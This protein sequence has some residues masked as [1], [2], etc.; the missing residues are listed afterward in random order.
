MIKYYE[1]CEMYYTDPYPIQRGRGLFNVDRHSLQR[2]RGLGGI[3]ASLLK[4]VIPFGKSFVKQAASSGK[5]FLKSDLGRDIINDTIA[6]AATAASSALLEQDPNEAKNIMK[7]S[8]KR[9]QNKSKAVVKRIARDKLDQV[10][11]GSG[12]KRIRKQRQRLTLLD[13]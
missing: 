1:K 5:K 9:S 4:K 10:L 13:L 8:L 11:T 6:S 12:G 2:G 3:F 7:E